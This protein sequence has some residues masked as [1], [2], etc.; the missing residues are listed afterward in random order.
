M[1]RFPDEDLEDVKRLAGLYGVKY[2]DFIL[3]AVHQAMGKPTDPYITFMMALEKSIRQQYN[4]T[5]F[6]PD[7]TRRIFKNIEET[8]ELRYQYE[9]ITGSGDERA[10]VNRKIGAMVAMLLEAETAGRSE[11]I[12]GELIQSHAMLLPKSTMM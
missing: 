2:D 10:K 7:V 11:H 4:I 3:W 8:T 5:D 12:D 9:S 1:V 6:P